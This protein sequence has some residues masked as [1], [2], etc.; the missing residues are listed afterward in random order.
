[1]PDRRSLPGEGPQLQESKI[2]NHADPL[3]GTKSKIDLAFPFL[4]LACAGVAGIL[5]DQDP[6]RG[7]VVAIAVAPLLL[8]LLVRRRPIPR[9][10]IDVALILFFLSVAIGLWATYNR[11]GSRPIEP[12]MMPPGWQWAWG[13]L[14]SALAFYALAAMDRPWQLGWALWLFAM[15]GTIGVIWFALTNEWRLNAVEV[16]AIKE[17]GFAIQ[18][19]YPKPEWLPSLNPNQVGGLLAMFW[20]YSVGVMVVGFR[21]GRV[22]QQLVWGIGGLLAALIIA[23]GLVLTVSRGAWVA[24]SAAAIMAAS[25][26]LAARLSHRVRWGAA[27]QLGLAVLAVEIIAVAALAF[28]AQTPALQV[29]LFTYSPGIA[30]RPTLFSEALLVARD[31]PFTGAG[32]GAFAM[33]HSTYVLL[34]P[35]PVKVHVHNMYLHVLTEQGVLGLVSLAATLLIPAWMGLR[36]LASSRTVNALL[37]ASL[38]S[39]AVEIVHGVWDYP[40]H[41]NRAILFLWVPAGVTLAAWRMAGG[42]WPMAFRRWRIADGRWR[43]VGGVILVAVLLAAALFWRP[44]AAAWEANMGAVAQAKTELSRYDYRHADELP[45]AK[46]RCDDPQGQSSLAQAERFYWQ[47]LDL[48][49][50]NATALTRLGAIALDCGDLTGARSLLQAAWDAGY[51]DRV[52]RLLYAGLLLA[53]GDAQTAAEIKRGLRSGMER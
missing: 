46:V 15:L 7:W 36:A 53:E 35:V 25:W 39:L 12:W 34:I 16:P 42:R 17:L 47:T 31:Y 3:Q 49:P 6:S 37:L 1:M 44:I 20:F 51:R 5:W 41:G 30:D 9:T 10:P 29:S 52:T 26:L 4:Q 45:L 18:A 38:A 22:R 32:L 50:R 2:H 28:L 11:D 19:R 33:I 24:A 13:L 14:L 21:S 8:R 40:L 43:V 23:F 27:G 48:D